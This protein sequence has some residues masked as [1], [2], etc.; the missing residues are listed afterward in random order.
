MNKLNSPLLIAGLAALALGGC[1]SNDPAKAVGQR[2]IERW[3]LLA[4]THA[5]KAY[6]YLTPG[7]R[8]THTL[9]QYVA[10][11]ATSRVHWKSAAVDNVHCEEDVCT[12]KILVKSVMPGSVI[13]RGDDL[14]ID[15]PVTEKWVRSDGQWFF[16]PDAKI[17]PVGV[18]KVVEAAS[19]AKESPA[20][21]D[22]PASPEQTTPPAQP[23]HV[24]NGNPAKQ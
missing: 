1:G 12:A 24:A 11:V 2:A 22:L 23:P 17:D 10:F 8:S 21:K 7:Y 18:A 15:L 3:D 13:G 19:E 5:V 20:A 9:E 4:G 14:Q 6:D 16:L